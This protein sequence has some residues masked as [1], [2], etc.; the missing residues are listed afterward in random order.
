[1][2][3]SFGHHGYGEQLNEDRSSAGFIFTGTVNQI[4][5]ASANLCLSFHISHPIAS[6]TS[7][8]PIYPDLDWY[9]AVSERKAVTARCP[10][11]TIH[12]CP[13]YF[14]SVA[15]L[16]DSG[17]TATLPAATH[18]T[19]LAKWQ[20]HELWPATA[21]TATSISGG[22]P[23]NCFSNFCPEV[24]FDTFKL[25]ASSLIRFSDEIDRDI[26]YRKLQQEGQSATR[27]W[28][29]DW[30]HIGPMHYSECP[31]YSKIPQEK[32][33]AQINNFHGPI[34]GQLNVAGQSINSPVLSLTVG[35]ILARVEASNATNEEKEAA[36]S[37]LSQFLTHPVVA[38]IVGGLTSRIGG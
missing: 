17:I 23:P 28:R 24:A 21:E 38:A 14:E 27:D 25:F 36:K 15:L 12:R 18:E 20:P 32:Q 3:S 6:D 22:Q 5:E 2:S 1:M 37:K 11:A 35:D 10:Y 30:E 7:M 34:T 4:A 19:A 26:R 31:I 8:T 29:W 16:S 33:V 13:R 9:V